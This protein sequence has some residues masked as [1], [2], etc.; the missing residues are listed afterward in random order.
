MKSKIF[1]DLF[2]KCKQEN[3][4][5]DDKIQSINNFFKD[6]EDCRSDL[7]RKKRKRF[8]E[9]KF[10]A[11]ENDDDYNE[12]D[13]I[14]YTTKLFKS[15]K[16]TTASEKNYDDLISVCKDFLQKYLCFETKDLLGYFNTIEISGE[17]TKPISNIRKRKVISIKKPL[18][19][20]DYCYKERKFEPL[21]NERYLKIEKF[22]SVPW[23]P[24]KISN[25]NI[26]IIKSSENDNYNTSYKWNTKINK[27]RLSYDEEKDSYDC[28][29][30]IK[31]FDLI[32]KNFK[33]LE[34]LIIFT[35]VDLFE[36]NPDNEIFGR[37]ISL[38]GKVAIVSLNNEMDSETIIT[39]LH[40][41]L[42]TFGII[43]CN[44]WN[45][46]MNPYNDVDGYSNID[47]C[48]LC[49]M[50]LKIYKNF[51]IL[52]RYNTIKE[53]FNIIEWNEDAKDCQNKID[54]IDLIDLK[55]NLNLNYKYKQ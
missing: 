32:V 33:D 44:I 17:N 48:P 42:H 22:K 14:I 34:S 21:C 29:N 5:K 27:F 19:R 46:L 13:R 24:N 45:C 25:A 37:T 15:S 16:M 6:L 30:L 53:A 51:D 31:P 55:N 38:G 35:N 11:K 7:L 40:E 9:K 49:L 2:P 39:C 8:K 12:K 10:N 20:F 4:K 41:T 50:K 52:K 18:R 54:L 47:L 28:Y 1:T 23:K 43:H 36:Q 26:K 3:R